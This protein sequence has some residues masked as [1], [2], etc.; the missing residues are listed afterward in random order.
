MGRIYHKD[1][2]DFDNPVKSYWEETSHPNQ[3]NYPKLS[4]DQKCDIVVILS[5]IHI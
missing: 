4:G 2:Y 5:L 3:E 1:I